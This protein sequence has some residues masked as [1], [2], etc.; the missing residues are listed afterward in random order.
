MYCNY[1]SVFDEMVT[2]VPNANIYEIKKNRDGKIRFPIYINEKL[3][4]TDLDALM[5]SVRANNCLHRAG[6]RTIGDVVE[7]I[8]SFENLKNIRNCGDK[9]IREITEKVFCYQYSQLDAS[10]K[11]KFIHRGLELN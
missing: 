1:Q 7:S 6:Y 3:K 10:K 8:D 4:T 9:S 2:L 5:L 11:I